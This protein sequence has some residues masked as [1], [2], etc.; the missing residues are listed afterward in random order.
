[1]NHFLIML[2]SFYSCSMY[3]C[4]QSCQVELNVNNT[5]SIYLSETSFKLY[6]C[7]PFLGETCSIYAIPKLFLLT[8]FSF[9]YFEFQ[10]KKRLLINL[11]IFL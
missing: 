3:T 5:Q 2:M 9:H 6:F 8:N 7:V 4:L 10:T 11:E 1:M